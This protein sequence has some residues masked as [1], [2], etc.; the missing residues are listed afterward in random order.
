VFSN[1]LIE[2]WWR[3]LKHGWLYLHTMEGVPQVRRLIAFYVEQHNAHTPHS[4]F[5]GET[6]DEMYFE[7]G[8]DVPDRLAEQRA[9]ARLRRKEVNRASRCAVCA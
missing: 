7:T 6:P 5:R 3:S 1:S 9:R 8:D 4:A 2:A